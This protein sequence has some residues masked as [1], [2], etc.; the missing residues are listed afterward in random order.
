[1]LMLNESIAEQ[2]GRHHDF[3]IYTY[4]VQSGLNHSI[5]FRVAVVMLDCKLRSLRYL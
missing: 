4:R 5:I 3:N 2:M 1:M